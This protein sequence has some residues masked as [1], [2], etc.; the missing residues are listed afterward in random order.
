[1]LRITYA[2][3]DSRQRWTLCGQLAGP[4]VAELRGCWEHRREAGV[5]THTVVDLSDVTF[6]DESGEKL[7]SQMRSNGAKF[8]GAGVDTTHLLTHLRT[9]GERS[10]RRFISPLCKGCEKPGNAKNEEGE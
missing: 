5:N 2:Q 9:K 6:I 10:L 8:V 3:T 4:W 7:L 1:M